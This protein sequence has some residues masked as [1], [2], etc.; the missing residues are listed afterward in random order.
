MPPPP[1]PFGPGGRA[2][3]LAGE[4][5]GSPNSDEGIYTVVLYL[6]KYF[7]AAGNPNQIAHRTKESS[8][9]VGILNAYEKNIKKTKQGVV[10]GM[11]TSLYYDEY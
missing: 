4:G 1:P 11:N 6:Y 8:L 5:L 2:H 7:V 3:S 10:S 9:T